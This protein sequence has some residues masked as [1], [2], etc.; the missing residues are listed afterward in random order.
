MG[1]LVVYDKHTVCDDG[2]LVL[3]AIGEVACSLC[4]PCVM[5]GADPEARWTNV[6]TN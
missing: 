6:I 2:R 4:I 3:D 5:K 1:I